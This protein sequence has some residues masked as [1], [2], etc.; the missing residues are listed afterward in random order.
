MAEE[1]FFVRCDPS[2]MAHDDLEHGRLLCEVGAA[3][4]CPAEFVLFR[5]G[6]KTAAP[7][8]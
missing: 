8:L 5:I 3:T 1:G 7:P 6:H 2:T 4:P